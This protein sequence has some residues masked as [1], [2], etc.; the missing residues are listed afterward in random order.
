M[1]FGGTGD[2][3]GRGS[4]RVELKDERLINASRETVYAALNDPEVLKQCIPGC[5]SLDKQDD[6]HFAAVAAVKVG[7]VKAR[8]NGAVELT[9]LNPPESYTLVGEGKGGV[10][11]FAKGRADVTLTEV[12]P[13]QT[14]LAYDVKAEVGGKLAQL[15]SRLIDSTAK[16][17]A[18]EF[19]TKF[20][21]VVEAKD[22]AAAPAEEPAPGAAPTVPMPPP[23]EDGP[24]AGHGEDQMFKPSRDPVEAA[25]ISPAAAG[26]FE[27]AHP[28]HRVWDEPTET[29][30]RDRA[31]HPTPE[32]QAAP[33]GTRPGSQAPSGFPWYW[34]VGAIVALIVIAWLIDLF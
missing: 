3:S 17:L 12:A 23:P 21:A 28:P 25:A 16:K 32:S 22:A 29:H 30:A 5:E 27:A 10:A 19:F 4:T 33:H 20:Q 14:T 24:P 18:G 1:S 8:F 6:T 26:A 15:G 2:R 34:I 31:E 9:N 11:G 7:P 13:D